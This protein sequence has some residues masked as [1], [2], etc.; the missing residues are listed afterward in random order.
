M[1]KNVTVA[2]WLTLAPA[3]GCGCRRAPPVYGSEPIDASLVQVLADPGQFDGRLVRVTGFCSIQFEDVAVYLHREDYDQMILK[4]AIWLD[5][6]DLEE[7]AFR[8]LQRKVGKRHC[9]IEGRLESRAHGHLGA[10]SGT[11]RDITRIEPS[12]SRAELEK[13]VLQAP[14]PSVRP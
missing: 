2:L 6:G 11:I 14:P 7:L 9:L 8:D 13:R 5:L 3:V 12:A 1:S 10:T 4:N